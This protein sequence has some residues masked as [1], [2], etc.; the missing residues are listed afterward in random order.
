MKRNGLAARLD[1]WPSAV[2]TLG[3]L[4]VAAVLVGV[5]LLPKHHILKTAVL[6]WVILP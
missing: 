6:A 5:A 2:L 4:T 1:S 3:L